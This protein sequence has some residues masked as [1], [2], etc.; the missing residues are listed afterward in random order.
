M[1]SGADKQAHE[2]EQ[3]NTVTQEVAVLANNTNNSALRAAESARLTREVAERGAQIVKQSIEG[4]ERIK[5]TVME[6]S[7]RVRSLGDSSDR[8]GEITTFIREIANRTNLLALNAT[9]EATRAGAAGKGFSVIADE[10]R[11]LAVRSGRATGEITWL[12]DDIQNGTA[13]AIMAMEI[14]NREVSEGTKMVDTAGSALKEILSAVHVST[15]SAGEISRATRHQLQSTQDIVSIME[16]ILKIAQQTA[17][18]AKKTEAE[19]TH[20]ESLSRS[21]NG[22]VAKFKLSS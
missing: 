22:A 17:Q 4:M 3:L 8:I 13:E 18:G 12:I 5:E 20:L 16:K 1:A 7:R 10:I 21:L 9:I 11:D 6:T 14:G 19:I 2:I 15:T